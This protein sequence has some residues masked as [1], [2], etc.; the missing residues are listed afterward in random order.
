MAM[1]ARIPIMATTIINSTRVKPLAPLCNF[2]RRFIMI[3][4][5]LQAWLRVLRLGLMPACDVT[6]YCPLLL[7]QCTVSCINDAMTQNK[8]RERQELL[9]VQF[10]LILSLFVCLENES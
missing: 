4:A 8:R 7:N 1:A 10:L 5:L 3:F 2:A 6:V 9:N